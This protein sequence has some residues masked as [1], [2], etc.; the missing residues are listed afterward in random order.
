MFL[1]LRRSLLLLLLA[2]A[3]GCPQPVASEA[4]AQ[5]RKVEPAPRTETPEEKARR[6]EAE[7]VRLEARV[8]KMRAAF[9]DDQERVCSADADCTLTPQHCCTCAAGGRQDA[10]NQ[11]RL[12]GL[13]G[14]RAVTCTDYACPQVVSDDPSCD[15][16]RAV[17]RD[18]R[19]APLVP[20]GA[21]T[22][23]GLGV[24]PIGA[25]SAA[26]GNAGP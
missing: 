13:I 24:E 1:S 9:V 19:C 11:A 5:W 8:K 18:G 7:R 23:G 15:A 2:F 6:A 16:V 20:A 3:G 17:C 22:T 14:R 4:D 10:V 21:A 12:P 26:S 25:E